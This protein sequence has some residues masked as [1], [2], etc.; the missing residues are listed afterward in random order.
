MNISVYPHDRLRSF[1]PKGSF[2]KLFG[3]KIVFIPRHMNEVLYIEDPVGF[4]STFNG[5]Y[6]A[7]P[8][9]LDA[10]AV[11]GMKGIARFLTSEV[12]RYLYALFG[13]TRI[14][15]RARLEKGDLESV[16]FPFENLRDAMLQGLEVRGED[17]ITRLF[18][19]RAGLG[20]A[21]VHAVSEYSIFRQGYEDSQLPRAA[22]DA[23][24]G[25]A[26]EHYKAML[27]SRLVDLF[28]AAADLHCVVHPP[29]DAEHFALI[30]IQIGRSKNEDVETAPTFEAIK[31]ALGFNPLA[32]ILFDAESSRVAVAKPWTRVAWTTE[33]AY[34]DAR[35]IS[36]EVLRYGASA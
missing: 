5:I 2:A 24:D 25:T 30:N 28:G 11:A 20:E 35:G 33:Q 18:A 31:A 19:E 3:G 10:G 8:A 4:V 26:V 22:L 1:T 14:L 7:D 29:A 9:T 17:E 27:N 34:A 23:P 15:D 12:A 6:A 13:K 32:R 21:F 16:P 36:E